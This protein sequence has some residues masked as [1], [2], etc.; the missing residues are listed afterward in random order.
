MIRRLRLDES[1]PMLSKGYSWLPDRRRAEGRDAVH[2]RLM[3]GQALAVEGPR[4]RGSST[5][6]TTSGAPMRSPSR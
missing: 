1:L 5:T 3:T 2:T 6:R 4:R